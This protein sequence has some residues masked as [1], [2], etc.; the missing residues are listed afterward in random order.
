MHTSL[1]MPGP[2]VGR[3]DYVKFIDMFN[4]FFKKGLMVGT[5][6]AIFLRALTDLGR[7]GDPDLVGNQWIHHEDN[8]IRLDLDFIAI[9]FAKYYWD[10]EVAF[11]MR[12]IPE[13]MA[14]V[15]N[16][17]NDLLI[18]KLINDEATKIMKK[19]VIDVVNDM[20]LKVRDGSRQI[21]AEI[22]SRLQMLTPPTLMK[23]A[24]DEMKEF[25][26]EVIRQAIRPEVL[27]N[28]LRD[29]PD[30]YER[31]K[32]EN[33]IMLNSNIIGFM[34]EFSYILKKALNYILAVHLEKNNPSARH[35]ATKIDSETEFDYRLQQVKKLETQIDYD[36]DQKSNHTDQQIILK[37]N[38]DI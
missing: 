4:D 11:K 21:N 19:T 15:N 37:K 35:I 28:L 29:M 14:D 24:S 10:M 36:F 20:D 34:K 27:K 32:R 9:R 22:D 3:E 16:P 33:H 7:Y 26:E 18:V 5:Y 17:E 30:L 8:K 12:H 23:F 31:V 38:D 25:R 1:V 6:K 13:N 2:T